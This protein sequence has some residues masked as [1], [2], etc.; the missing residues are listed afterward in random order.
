MPPQRY[1]DAYP[2]VKW[3]SVGTGR[4]SGF[5]R[6]FGVKFARAPFL[7]FLDADDRLYFEAVEKML[8]E[9]KQEEAV[10][11]SDYVGKAFIADVGELDS[12]LQQNIL[13]R[14]DDGLTVIKYE[15]LDYDVERAQR[16]PAGDP[17]KVY[18]WNL[19]TSLVP[20]AWHEEIG[21]FDEGMVSWEDV[22][23]W[24][25][26]AKRGKCFRRI[27][28]PLVVYHFY[29]GWRRDL[30]LEKH[31]ELFTYLIEKHEKEEV[32]GCRSCGGSRTRPAA[33]APTAGTAGAPPLALRDDQFQ[34]VQYNHPSRGQ[35]TTVGQ[36]VFRQKID[37]VNMVRDRGGQGFRI[38]YGWRGG[39]EK[40]LAHVEDIRIAPHL[41][42][43]IETKPA[44]PRVERRE[45]PAPKTLVEVAEAYVEEEETSGPPPP[46]KRIDIEAL[47]QHEVEES[48]A[49]PVPLSTGFDWQKLPGVTDKIAE[50]LNG[51]GLED[52]VKMGIEGLQEIPYVGPARAKTIFAAATEALRGS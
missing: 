32:M 34:M 24:W 28:E 9:W 44:A 36:A 41:F 47:M 38:N 29:T 26:M 23:Y 14:E 50:K 1:L 15:A 4:G 48:V 31:Q 10:I 52:V 43:P 37:G 51:Y 22:D 20:K 8:D 39:G 35:Q 27:P 19:I 12:K 13:W 40:F 49:A 46:P 2:F 30:G 16:Q 18:T 6:N 11:Y 33:P 21:G 45:T 3:R 42:T 7:L 25:R 17:R 5:A